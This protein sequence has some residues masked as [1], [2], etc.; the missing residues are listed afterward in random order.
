MTFIQYRGINGEMRFAQKIPGRI[1]QHYSACRD[2]E[3][4]AVQNGNDEI[5]QHW[6]EQAELLLSHIKVT[7]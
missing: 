4:T 1:A 3:Y 2:F 5:A 6:H 7:S